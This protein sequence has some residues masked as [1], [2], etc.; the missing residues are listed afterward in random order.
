[1]KT[2]TDKESYKS[3]DIKMVVLQPITVICQSSGGSH[4][5]PGDDYDDIDMD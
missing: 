4:Q 1:M 2:S 3:P 5:G